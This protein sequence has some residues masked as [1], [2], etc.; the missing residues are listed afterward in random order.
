MMVSTN[1]STTGSM[2]DHEPTTLIM[3]ARLPPRIEEPLSMT[4]LPGGPADKAG[5]QYEQWWTARVVGELLTD[6]ASR[7]RLEPPGAGGDG[8]EF[9]V[10]RDGQTWG[11]QVK[12][13]SGNWTINRLRD[14]GVLANALAQVQRGRHFRLV[15]STY[16]TPF[17]TLTERSTDCDTVAELLEALSSDD[18]ADF[19]K[20]A[21]FWGLAEDNAFDVLRCI[22]V[23]PHPAENLRQLVA[24]E[25]R[26]LFSDD[27]SVVL[28]ELRNF[29]DDH[30][31]EQVTAPQVW[32][33][34]HAKGFHRRHLAGDASS[35][36]N[37]HK[38]VERHARNVVDRQPDIGLV[39]S[40]YLD[41]LRACLLLDDGK[42]LVVVDGNAGF[43]KSTVVAAVA[44]EMEAAGW[45]VAAANMSVVPSSVVTST[46]L[47]DQLGL[48]DNSPG[49][50]L[51][52]VA[53]GGKGLLVIDQ[54]D[55]VGTYSGRITEVYDSI[56]EVLNELV[57]APNIKVLLVVRTID[58]ESDSRFRHFRNPK[59]SN[60]VRVGRLSADDVSAKLTDSGIALPAS[61]VTM[62]LLRT[63]LHLSIFLRLSEAAQRESYPTLQVLYDRY[64]DETRQAIESAVG[65]LQWAGIMSL[66]VDHMNENERL[67]APM[68]LLDSY[69]RDEVRALESADVLSVNDQGVLSFF[70][71]SYFDYLFAH[72]FV[73]SDGSLFD[74][75]VDSGQH[76]FRRSQIRQVLEHLA[77]TDRTKFR[78]AVQQMLSSAEIRSHLKEVVVDVLGQ[79]DGTADDWL[80]VDDVA[81]G[82]GKI[83]WRVLN[84]LGR[85]SWFS[86]VDGLG[87]W[88][89]W[90]AD[91]ARTDRAFNQ[92]VFLARD[93]PGRVVELVRPFVGTDD[94]W[95]KRLM[96]LIEW[97]LK[98]ESSDFAIELL[99]RGDLDDA[100]GPIA[101]NSDF[102]SIVFG[103]ATDDPSAAARFIGAYLAR[104]LVRAK[105]EGSDDPFASGHLPDHSQ[106]DE[107]I[108]DVATKAPQ[109]YLASVFDFVEAVAT[110]N[111]H[112]I[113]GH[114]P[115]GGRWS[116]RYRNTAYGVD[117]KIFEG[118]AQALALLT[119][120]EPGLCDEYVARL[121]AHESAEL[122][123]L[124]CGV[125]IKR[126]PADTAIAWLVDDPRNLELGYA[127]NGTWASRSLIDRW[128]GECSDELFRR[129]EEL[130]LAYAPEWEKRS[131]GA[132]RLRLLSA[133]EVAR[134]S[135]EARKHLGELERKFPAVRPAEAPRGIMGGFVGP[136]IPDVAGE[137][138][139]DDDWLRALRKYTSEGTDWRGDQPVGGARELAQMLGRRAEQE[140][141]RFAKLAIGFGSDVHAAAMDAV[142][143]AVATKI[144]SEELSDLC[145]HA[146]HTFGSEVGR[147][148]CSAIQQTELISARLSA[149][150]ASYVD[151]PDPE[152]EWATTQASSGADYYGGDFDSAGLNC[153]RGQV[154]LAAATALFASAEHVEALR[155]VVEALAVDEMMSVR[156]CAAEAVLALMN[157]DP[158]AA[159][160][161]GEA[162][163]DADVQLYN[164]RGVE[165]LMSYLLVREP[166]RFG[167]F[168]TRALDGPDSVATRAGR[169]W[170]L[171]SYR[172]SLPSDVPQTSGALS[173]EARRGVAE[174]FARNAAESVEL[175]VALFDDPDA[176]VRK[177]AASA[178]RYLGSQATSTIATLVQGF[179]PSKAFD[180]RFD[181]LIR[182]LQ[183]VESI[184]GELALQVC[185]RAIAA[186]AAEVGDIRTARSML[187]QPVMVTLLRVYRHGDTGQRERCLDVIDRLSEFN[188]HG[189]AEALNE[190]R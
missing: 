9:E 80:A 59:V 169:L 54:L 97:S 87:K 131:P 123:F 47:G 162:L 7:I 127:D 128:S 64:T 10:D 153:T 29:C 172:D 24:A 179:L 190:E 70:H 104:G 152:R 36:N 53:A 142:L 90:L 6:V 19:A 151:D 58:L 156:T 39:P 23:E 114:F 20:L 111:P 158:E 78:E 166:A 56:A 46:K 8:I 86:A 119:E 102:W 41:Q 178:M 67:S 82:D 66:L 116:H 31:H 30:M 165:R 32:A 60:R 188:A 121:N 2:W 124:V 167:Q 141:A 57:S 150:I 176:E 145:E 89:E 99:E 170:A 42:Q 18:A 44:A 5:N 12:L 88:A 168:L 164:S 71:E 175:L 138:M 177:R 76:L 110:A 13:R 61:N 181:E 186:A 1:A 107:I 106:S 109:Q 38:T 140:P 68:A 118:V 83:A 16:A 149:L 92:L 63:P 40:T 163:L 143:R 100:R 74:F 96:S 122:H 189:L 120:V 93:H 11:E 117:D 33:H 147:A 26:L 133:L 25:F 159:Y 160:D 171:L 95:R 137:K 17:D 98:P 79:V 187:A 3:N 27:P 129:L 35:I 155:P 4:A 91:P 21:G 161:L 108:S 101:V 135:D 62:E 65:H 85:P 112:E 75:V 84:L 183:S 136:P 148:V 130:I 184:D 144:D 43:G 28:G 115:V 34:L 113:E 15:V 48:G 14:E 37:L 125:L 94:D 185:E 22:S 51:A 154:A 72:S 180:E 157:Y 139:S 182:E 81:W 134:L 73:A 105:A 174:S 52:G 126:G 45:F 55:A 49:V 146:Q 132:T 173:V 50:L 103:L 69:P 77:A